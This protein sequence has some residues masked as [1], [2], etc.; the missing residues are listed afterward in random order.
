MPWRSLVA[1]TDSGTPGL[2]ATSNF[3]VTVNPTTHPVVGSV[4]GFGR[5]GESDGERAA[6]FGLH[7]VDFNPHSANA[8]I[9]LRSSG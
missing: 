6:G 4:D 7:S 3:T 8:E 9:Q 1:I 5:A 2:S